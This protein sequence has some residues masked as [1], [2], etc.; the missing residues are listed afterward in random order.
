MEKISLFNLIHLTLNFLQN[1]L[2]IKIQKFTKFNQNLLHRN[3]TKF[4]KFFSKSKIYRITRYLRFLIIRQNHQKMVE[5]ITEKT[6]YITPI[7]S[8]IRQTPVRN[9]EISNRLSWAYRR[10]FH[11]H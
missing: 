4:E 5:T 10:E 1:Y 8:T 11:G 6:D 9:S 3:F 7:T 2:H